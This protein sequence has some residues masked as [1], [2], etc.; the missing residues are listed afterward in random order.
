MHDIVR[1]YKLNPL[2][3]LSLLLRWLAH[4]VLH[5]TD[6]AQLHVSV[7]SCSFGTYFLKFHIVSCHNN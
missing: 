7:C 2:G 5:Y 1:M 6:E 3:A 4:L